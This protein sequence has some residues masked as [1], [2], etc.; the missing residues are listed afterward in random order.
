MELFKVGDWVEW[1][2]GPLDPDGPY[3]N[4]KNHWLYHAPGHIRETDPID[5]E[6]KYFEPPPYE[7]CRVL[8][9]K[10]VLGKDKDLIRYVGHPQF[11]TIRMFPSAR[12]LEVDPIHPNPDQRQF[13]GKLFKVV[14]P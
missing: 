5:H 14:C 3:H 1:R 8:E 4:D 12:K 13:S 10:S 7:V 11:V 2:F 6:L 9:V